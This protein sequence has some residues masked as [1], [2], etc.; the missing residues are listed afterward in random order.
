MNPEY[1]KFYI[2]FVVFVLIG[3]IVGKALRKLQ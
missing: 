3:L 2:T 1:V